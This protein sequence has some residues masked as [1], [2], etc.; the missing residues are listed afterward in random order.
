MENSWTIVSKN[1]NKNDSEKFLRVRPDCKLKVRLIGKP[2]KVF[3]VFVGG[4]KCM[5]L[6]S[7]DVGRQLRAKY[8]DM[9][10]NV[11]VR[12]ACWAIDRKDNALK[13]LDMPSTVARS[14]GRRA[15]IGKKISSKEGCDFAIITNYKRRSKSVPSGGGLAAA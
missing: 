4:R 10:G 1:S 14:I 7:E 15:V 8:P 9:V 12:Y 3:K 6:N 2:V 11:S 13:I 5:L